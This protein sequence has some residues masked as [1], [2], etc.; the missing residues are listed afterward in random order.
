MARGKNATQSSVTGSFTP[1]K[2]VDGNEDTFAI[3][4]QGYGQWWR[5]D[6]G[7]QFIIKSIQLKF[8]ESF[9]G[10]LK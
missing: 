1:D 9:P 5:L 10:K 6:L 3:T 7:E 4:N 2:A 8:S